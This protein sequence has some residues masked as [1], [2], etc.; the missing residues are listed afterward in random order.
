MDD[1]FQQMGPW[2]WVVGG[3]ILLVLEIFVAVPGSL[4]LFTGIAALIVGASA[5]LFEW[6]WQFQLIGFAILS[7][8]LVIGGR[9]YFA[10]RASSEGDQGLNE[11]AGR[12]VGSIYVLVEPIVDGNGRVKVGDSSWGVSG[13]DAPVGTRVKVVSA[14]GAILR[15]EVV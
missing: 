7:A 8:V 14:D 2:K 3:L 6:G 5:L 13:P 9:R 15:V 11:R 10:Q 4:F 12:L 1:F